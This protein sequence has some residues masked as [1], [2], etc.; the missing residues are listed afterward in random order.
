MKKTTQHPEA[1]IKTLG[2]RLANV[3]KDL[4]EFSTLSNL[5]YQTDRK[6]Q[7]NTFSEIM[8]SILYRLVALNPESPVEN[9]IRLGMMTFTASIFFRWRDMKQRQAYLDGSFRDALTVLRKASVQPPRAVVLW[10][11][12]L[13][14]MNINGDGFDVFLEWTCEILRDMEIRSWD[15]IREVLKTVIWIDCLFDTPGR[16]A[17]EPILAH[18]N[19]Q[20]RDI[21]L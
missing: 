2:P 7:P 1:F 9:V 8:I 17:F 20:P 12:V 18:V 16:R 13:W 19:G 10:L 4:H 6:L 11:L 14:E 15:G 21:E 5:A 3:W